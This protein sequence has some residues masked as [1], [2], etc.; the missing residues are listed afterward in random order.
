ME[1]KLAPPGS[2]RSARA[3]SEA[4]AVESKSIGSRRG[5]AACRLIC[6][7]LRAPTS[8]GIRSAGSGLGSKASSVDPARFRYQAL[9]RAAGYRAWYRCGSSS[10]DRRRGVQAEAHP[11][12]R[13]RCRRLGLPD[14]T[15]PTKVMVDGKHIDVA[16]AVLAQPY[17]IEVLAREDA[18]PMQK[19]RRCGQRSCWRRLDECTPHRQPPPGQRHG[20][21]LTILY[22]GD[23]PADAAQVE[24]DPGAAFRQSSSTMLVCTSL[25]RTGTPASD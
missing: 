3:G 25:L 2:P 4:V 15:A 7:R 24:H 18:T 5:L 8:G 11:G 1:S 16:A 21:R 12:R 17:T 23:E 22:Q 20:R 13:D 6:T 19:R 9:A 10:D 14:R